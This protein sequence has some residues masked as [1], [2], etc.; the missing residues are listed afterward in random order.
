MFGEIRKSKPQGT[1][2]IS[3]IGSRRQAII[4]DRDQKQ[5]IQNIQVIKT[6]RICLNHLMPT[7]RR[8]AMFV[9]D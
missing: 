1:G 2:W 8:K 4:P 6:C 7:C 9:S 3:T 5:R